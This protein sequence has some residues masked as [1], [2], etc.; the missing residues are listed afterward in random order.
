VGG[1]EREGGGGCITR[2]LIGVALLA[3]V[4]IISDGDNYQCVVCVCIGGGC[5]AGTVCNRLRLPRSLSSFTLIRCLKAHN[6][7]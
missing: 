5:G 2:L 1:G 3:P 4:K 7:M 6:K